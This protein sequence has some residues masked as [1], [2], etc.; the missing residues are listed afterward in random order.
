MKTPN[1]HEAKSTLS[2]LVDS[3]LNGEVV[4][5]CKAGK[6][7]VK[8]TPVKSTPRIPGELKGKIKIADDFDELPDDFKAVFGG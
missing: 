2:Q 6:P 1:L 3:A 7:A 5:I 4:I 8:L